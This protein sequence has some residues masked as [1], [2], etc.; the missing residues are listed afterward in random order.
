MYY[1]NPTG[2]VIP[3]H[4]NLIAPITLGVG[5]SWDIGTLYKNKNK[6]REAEVERRELNTQRDQ[7]LDD[8]HEDVHK[9]FV[10][11]QTAQAK[12]KLL[13]VAVDQAKENERI[14]ESKFQN[15]LVTTTDRIDAQSQL[16]QAR[17]NLQLA[18]SEAT[19]DYY[20]VLRSTGKIHL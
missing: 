1:I 12:L 8:I 17:I 6:E 5:A 9:Q 7:A 2:E 13:Q 15:N 16:Y 4:N 11:Y 10:A 14:T 19:I 18:Q 3:T 20:N